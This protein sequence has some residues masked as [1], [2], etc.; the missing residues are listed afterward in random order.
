MAEPLRERLFQ[1]GLILQGGGLLTDYYRAEQEK[2]RYAQQQE[3][4]AREDAFVQ[5]QRQIAERQR[6]KKL[7]LERGQ[8]AYKDLLGMHEF[9]TQGRPDL[10]VQ[11]GKSRVENIGEGNDATETM[12]YMSAIKQA[13][14]SGQG[15]GGVIQMMTDDL[16]V[17]RKM[18]YAPEDN[19]ESFTL[20]PGQTRFRGG[21]VVATAPETQAQLEDRS[22]KRE[23]QDLR[24][25]ESELRRLELQ[26]RRETNEIKKQELENKIDRAKRDRE[27]NATASIQSMDDSIGTIDR[28]LEGGALEG[29]VGVESNFPTVA[30]SDSATFESQLET[31]QSQ[32]FIS[33]VSKLKGLG[34]LSDAEGKKLSAAIGSLNL[35]MKDEAFRSELDRIKATLQVAKSRLRKKFGMEE[36]S[37]TAQKTVEVDF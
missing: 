8:A 36:G 2:Q 6:N 3:R 30:G 18:G 19:T 27:F 9:L 11:L 7:G 23:S 28:M 26:S 29:A 10:A 25:Q 24:R 13:A 16:N 1:A 31:F 12:Q 5:Q 15:F 37:S 32:A 33:Q 21:Q 34:A 35:S 20:S 4:Q 17:G 22:I 14:D